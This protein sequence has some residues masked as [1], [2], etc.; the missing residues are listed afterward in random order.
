VG[1]ILIFPRVQTHLRLRLVAPKLAEW[2]RIIG[3]G[4]PAAGEFILMFVIFGVVY[5]VIRGFGP[6]AQAGFGVGQRVAQSIF[7]PAMA[8]A[9]A[10]A[11]IAGQNFGAGR[12]DRVRETFR[13]AALIGSAIMFA[14][15]LLCQTKPEILLTPFTSDPDALAVGKSYLH[16]LSWNFVATGIAFTCS[17]MFQGLGDTRP[18]FLASATRLVTFAGPAIWLSGRPGTTLQ[19]IWWLSMASVYLQ[20]GISFLFLRMSLN[21]KL[22]GLSPRVAPQGAVA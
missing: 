15:T 4:L 17:S 21:K 22:E 6:H 16:T 20:A 13:Q 14:L 9:F 8:V 10:A 2:G 7:L 3:I 12:G 5:W 18:S 11:P 1:L 19:E